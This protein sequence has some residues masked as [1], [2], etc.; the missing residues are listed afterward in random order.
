MKTNL[1][2]SLVAGLLLASGLAFSQAPMA[3]VPCDMAG[4]HGYMHGQGMHQ[5]D[6]G[7]M[8]PAKM[9]AY[10]D[11]RHA[12]LKTQLKLTTAQEP[13]WT[14]FVDSHKVPAGM[15]GQPPA[16]M[17]DLAK[18]TT[19]ERIDKMKALRAQRMSEMT[20][21]MDQRAEAIKT[22]YAVLTPEQQKVFDAQTMQGHRMPRG[23]KQ[24]KM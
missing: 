6:M 17:A 18:L 8:N 2:I 10:M 3:D 19:P 15:K 22:F 7:R 16:A 11:K 23:M 9:Q 5:R 4:P 1:K 14:A 21:A 24:P 13:A 20:A 12:A